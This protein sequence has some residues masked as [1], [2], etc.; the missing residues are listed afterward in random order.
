VRRLIAAILLAAG[1][2]VVG[3]NP[4]SA[5]LARPVERGTQETPIAPGGVVSDALRPLW[6]ADSSPTV[7]PSP[8][9]EM[10]GALLALAAI[11]VALRF[12]RRVLG[13]GLALVLVVLAFESGIHSVHHLGSSQSSQETK[14][15]V[16]GVATHVQ[17]TVGE[18]V[19]AL[20][21]PLYTGAASPVAGPMRHVEQTWRAWR[22][23][24]PPRDSLV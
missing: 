14:C 18:M 11:V 7:A 16:A 12:R 13:L 8:P 2:L 17:G 5:H 9:L 10:A 6:T 4:A 21:K 15:A 22:G 19:I 23:R 20:A 1:G 3:T 24:A